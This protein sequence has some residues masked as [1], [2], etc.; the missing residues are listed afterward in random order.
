MKRKNI[1]PKKLKSHPRRGSGREVAIPDASA[2]SG[3]HRGGGE[4]LEKYL[5]RPLFLKDQEHI[6][7]IQTPDKNARG[8]SP[9]GDKSRAGNGAARGKKVFYPSD[10]G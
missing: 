2:K 9:G 8:G 5:T 6:Y 10:R 4:V 7:T 3:S 1:A